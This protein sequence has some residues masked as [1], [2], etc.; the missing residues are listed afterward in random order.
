MNTTTTDPAYQA[1]VAHVQDQQD[2]MI[3]VCGLLEAMD[4]L[5][6]MKDMEDAR[7][8]LLAIVREKADAVRR[9]LDVQAIGRLEDGAA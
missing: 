1:L 7:F 9:A 2:S 4:R 8:S 5:M 6:E 3:T